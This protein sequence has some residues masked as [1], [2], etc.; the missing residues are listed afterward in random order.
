MKDRRVAALGVRGLPYC[1]CIQV[2]ARGGKEDREWCGEVTIEK[3]AQS[4]SP[5]ELNDIVVGGIPG[6]AA[7]NRR[8]A[9]S[10]ASALNQKRNMV[11]AEAPDMLT[12]LRCSKLFVDASEIF[13]DV[14]PA[15]GSFV[16]SAARC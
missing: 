12:A 7:Q 6:E 16:R 13:M 14:D 4:R 8:E 9:G 2:T 10:H 11:V 15:H 3:E 5:V 1:P